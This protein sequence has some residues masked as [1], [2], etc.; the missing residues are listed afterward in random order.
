MEKV[1]EF[2]R[3]AGR[4]AAGIALCAVCALLTGCAPEGYDEPLL[5]SPAETLEIPPLTPV[6][7]DLSDAAARAKEP[8][9]SEGLQA[10]GASLRK[11]AD[12]LRQSP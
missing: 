6:A 2:R 11:R 4:G 8:D 7:G 12:A 10:R 5:F 3:N 9:P 1:G